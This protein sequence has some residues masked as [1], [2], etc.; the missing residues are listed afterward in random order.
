VVLKAARG[1]IED[2]FQLEGMNGLGLAGAELH[3]VIGYNILA[4]FRME[5]DFTRDKMVWTPLKFEPAAPFD[6]AEPYN[7]RGEFTLNAKLEV[8]LN[9]S[10]QIPFGM[11]THRRPS[12]GLLG[13]RVPGR[14]ADFMCFAGKQVEEI[15][16]TFADGLPLP[17]AINGTTV[18]NKYFSYQSRYTMSGRTLA[19]RREF[20]SNV[21]SQVCAKEIES[22][23]NEPLQRV[24]RNMQVQMSFQPI[25]PSKDAAPEE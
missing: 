2:P 18:D 20:K 10:R 13:Q 17:G 23:L 22:E 3:G 9:G 8:P 4:R 12:V 19:I 24:A 11:P 5:I 25:A 15:D 7:L 1:R 6:F 21:T 14:R 16:L